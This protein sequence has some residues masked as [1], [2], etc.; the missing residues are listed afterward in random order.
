MRY[1][2]NLGVFMKKI[3][4]V[5][6]LLMMMGFA[7]AASSATL[8]FTTPQAGST[9]TDDTGSAIAAQFGFGH[10]NINFTHTYTFSTDNASDL[11]SGELNILP[12]HGALGIDIASITLD[13]LA[14]SED[15]LERVWFGNG[16]ANTVA[17]SLTI[18]G[19]TLIPEGAQYQLFLTASDN[20]PGVP[21]PAAIWLF[22]SGIAGLLGFTSRKS[23]SKALIA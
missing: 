4:A 7:G 23:A 2:C 1:F 13:G 3:S 19:K 16:L 5:L 15:A 20:I 6:T 17:H 11:V 14:W 12:R 10:A 8:M 18:V 22:G 9:V 21:V